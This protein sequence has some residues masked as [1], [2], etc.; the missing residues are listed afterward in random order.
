MRSPDSELVFFIFNSRQASLFLSTDQHPN[1]CGSWK[2]AQPP[3]AELSNKSI[4]QLL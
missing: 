1:H 3:D 2:L 4:M